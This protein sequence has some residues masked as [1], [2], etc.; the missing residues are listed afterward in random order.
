MLTTSPL[1]PLTHWGWDVRT[2]PRRVAVAPGDQV[3]LVVE[4]GEK[5]GIQGL[6][7]RLAEPPGS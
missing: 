1:T 7:V 2:F 5:A 6:S 4:V 3:P